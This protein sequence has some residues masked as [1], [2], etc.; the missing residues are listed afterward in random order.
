[1]GADFEDEVY[2]GGIFRG[3]DMLVGTVFGGTIASMTQVK[4]DEISE[5]FAKVIGAG[6]QFLC[7]G[8]VW[9]SCC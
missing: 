7:E 8:Q 3:L 9:A 1:M 6:P 4:A 5:N 2:V